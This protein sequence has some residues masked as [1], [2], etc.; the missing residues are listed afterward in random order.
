[1]AWAMMVRG[2]RFKEPKLWHAALSRGVLSF[3]SEAR[4]HRAVKRRKFISL[5]GAATAVWPLAAHAQQSELRRIGVLQPFPKDSPEKVRIE[6]FLKELQRLGWT[7]GR[8]VQIEYRRQTSD[9]RKAAMELVA[10]SPDVILVSTTPAVSAMQTATQTIPVVFTQVADPVSAG[11]VASLAK[12]GGNIT[13]FMVFDYEIAAKW[14]ELLKEIAPNVT[15]VGVIRD[16][17]VTASIGQ[18]AAIQSAARLSR[19]EVIPLGGRDSKDIERTVTE[20]ARGPNCGLIAVGSPLIINNSNLIIS[21]AAR[22][23]LPATYPWRSSVTAG[24]LIGYGPD[25]IDAHRQA[26]GYVD[27]ILKGERPADLP[28]QAPVKYELVI[29][30]KTARALGL[31]VPPSLLAL[32]DEVI[33]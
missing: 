17:A 20:F 23:R 25:P 8:N 10:L 33:E 31:T 22:H 19:V 5:L 26:A 1:M 21:L 9:L 32:A 30:V 14:L 24:G 27:R 6:A 15:R 12:P 13:G 3:R 2:E 7:D 16:P 18:L 11:I 4:R 28:V 29:N